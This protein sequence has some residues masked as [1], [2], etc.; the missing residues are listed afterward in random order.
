MVGEEGRH[1]PVSEEMHLAGQRADFGMRGEWRFQLAAEIVEAGG[2]KLAGQLHRQRGL[3]K[4]QDT[5]CVRNHMRVGAAVTEVERRH[6][7]ARLSLVRRR[8]NIAV[9]IPLGLAVLDRYA[10]NHPIAEEPVTGLASKRIGAVPDIKAAKLGRNGAL[11]GQ[12]D[13]R[14][15][16]LDR[17]EIALHPIGCLARSFLHI[18]IL[19]RLGISAK[20]RLALT[21]CTETPHLPA[22]VAGGQAAANPVGLMSRTHNKKR[23]RRALVPGGTA[24]RP[25][26]QFFDGQAVF[27]HGKERLRPRRCDSIDARSPSRVCR[28][29]ESVAPAATSPAPLAPQGFTRNSAMSLSKAGTISSRMRCVSSRI[30]FAAGPAFHSWLRTSFMFPSM[31]S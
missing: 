13:R 12:V 18:S 23:Q 26:S 5:I 8:A 25:V 4:R 28:Q 7:R 15:L 1:R 29:S 22:S 31:L 10:M 24:F 21:F 17:R 9:P 3:V 27:N 2:L 16:V 11:H 19:F 20:Q 14:H 6:R 30:A